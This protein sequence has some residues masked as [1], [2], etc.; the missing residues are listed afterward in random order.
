M[1][2]KLLKQ[3]KEETEE[4][5]ELAGVLVHTGT[6]ES[7]HYYSYIRD[8]RPRETVPDPKVQWFEFNDSEVKPWRIEEL[9]HWCFGGQEMTYDPAYY[10]EPP[11]KSYSAYMLFYRRRPKVVGFPQIVTEL[12][13]PPPSLRAEVQRYNDNFVR[14]YVIYG[15][16]LSA[17]VA[18]LLRSMPLKETSRLEECEIQELEEHGNDLYPL[19]LGLQVYR[20][21]VSRMDFRS[22][23]EKFC[24]ALQYAVR[25]SPAARH[26][27]YAWLQKTPGCLKELLLS[28]INEKSRSQSAQLIASA[29]TGDE[30]AKPRSYNPENGIDVLDLEVVRSVITDIANL[31]YSA[32]DNW[33]SWSEY[34]ETLTLIAKD[35]DW[36]RLLIE[37]NMIAN[38]A[39]HFVHVFMVRR[40][41][42][43][44]FGRLKYPDNE[45]LRPNYKKL[46]GLLAQLIQ[47]VII[48][49]SNPSGDRNFAALDEPGWITDE[50]WNLLFLEW[51]SDYL[52]MSNRRSTLNVFV[53][54]LFETSCEVADITTLVKWMLTEAILH[55]NM[56]SQKLAILA[57]L[58]R[59][60]D[61]NHINATEA[62]DVIWKL[63]DD[64]RLD[65]ENVERWEGSL[66]LLV[67]RI[68]SWSEYLRDSFYGQDYLSFWKY[69]YDLENDSFRAIF[70]ANLPQI[71]SQLIYS[72]EAPVR[73][74]TAVWLQSLIP[75]FL[76]YD[77][78][79]TII[80]CVE[81]L[82]AKLLS[83]TELFLERKIVITERYTTVQSVVVPVLEVLKLISITFPGA[84]NNLESI[85][86]S[87]AF[88]YKKLTSSATGK[89][90]VN[91]R[92]A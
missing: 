75:K 1:Q 2:E 17:F 87:M 77:G 36:A 80:S 20:L 84:A 37:E 90:E 24:T 11:F 44:G 7:G 29:L 38:T 81:N 61:P 59:Q 68:A 9:D 62:L 41:A 3:P 92:S 51:D 60:A 89:G 66:L 10:P 79:I 18:K 70:L 49:Q 8:P 85:I 54:R 31:V 39:Y 26:Y 65:D 22:S 91:S 35:P 33:R 14:R 86:E 48:T 4:I 43:R 50:E 23:V 72:N 13:L 45:R 56:G 82:R 30:V 28:N 12:R 5:Y 25:S 73:D 34:F 64:L 53:H 46:V 83:Q 40:A 27:F 47:H 55:E 42:P 57:T 6:A 67:R 58:C 19:V 74:R 15:E 32:G 69:V 16:D 71:A 52:M 76:D 78:D 88:M 63:F 21:V